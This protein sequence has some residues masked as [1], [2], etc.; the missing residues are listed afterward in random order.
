[1]LHVYTLHSR[2]N[3]LSPLSLYIAY[4]LLKS[5]TLVTYK[6][7]SGYTPYYYDYT[8]D[9]L[10][11]YV[12]LRTLRSAPVLEVSCRHGIYLPPPPSRSECELS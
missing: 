4:F 7:L 12:P 5:L 3:P 10:D 6:A 1:M 11:Q 8:E 9:R 2:T